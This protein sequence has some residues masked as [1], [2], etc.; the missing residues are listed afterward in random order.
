MLAISRALGDH[1]LK[2]AGV[3]GQPSL[4]KITL[5]PRQKFMIVACDGLFDVLS[6]QDALNAVAG[7]TDPTK[8]AQKLVDLALAEGTTDNVSVMIVKLQDY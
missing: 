3:T 7:M 2:S 6:D 4:N 5:R 8:M 1:G